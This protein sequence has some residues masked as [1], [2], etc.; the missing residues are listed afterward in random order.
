MRLSNGKTFIHSVAIR[1]TN[2]YHSCPYREPRAT[3]LRSAIVVTL[4]RSDS[5]IST[6][7]LRRQEGCS[8]RCSL[9]QCLDNLRIDHLRQTW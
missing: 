1:S 7:E 9:L 2:Y 5:A 6:L 8:L 4:D 3:I